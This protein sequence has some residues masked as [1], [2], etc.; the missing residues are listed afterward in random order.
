MVII[1]HPL[2]ATVINGSNVE[3]RND[4]TAPEHSTS[5][6]GYVDTNKGK[7]FDTGIIPAG[8][9]RT[10]TIKGQGTVNYFCTLHPWMFGLITV[11][12]SSTGSASSAGT[13]RT[14]PTLM[15]AAANQLELPLPQSLGQML[16]ENKP[17]T[18]Y[19][20]QISNPKI[21]LPKPSTVTLVTKTSNK[22]CNCNLIN[23]RDNKKKP[24]DV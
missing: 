1:D 23:L 7:I 16:A 22:N 19:F 8:S 6:I 21:S 12:S 2:A 17:I 4:D 24:A 14:T 9:S 15:A 10:V 20:K 11:L 5:G 13:V 18:T 3:W